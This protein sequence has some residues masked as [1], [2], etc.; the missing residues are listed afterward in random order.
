MIRKKNDDDD[1]RSG[2]KFE[3][4]EI[5]VA[6][7]LILLHKGRMLYEIEDRLRLKWGSKRRRSVLNDKD[8]SPSAI[9]VGSQTLKLVTCDVG[10]SSTEPAVKEPRIT[11]KYENSSPASPLSFPPSESEEKPNFLKRKR[12]GR[13]KEQL[14]KLINEFTEGKELLTKEHRTVTTYYDNL[15][16]LNSDLKAKIEEINAG[17]KIRTPK[18]GIGESSNA[19]MESCQI[20][21]CPSQRLDH[22]P[23]I[24]IDRRAQ[25]RGN[26]YQIPDL[27]VSVPEEECCWSEYHPPF[28]VS[29]ADVKKVQMA[30][31]ARK[32]RLNICRVKS[33]VSSANKLRYP[34]T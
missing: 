13:N 7:S 17:S 9:P 8:S 23:L 4:R 19:A 3:A 1:E 31:E 27:N 10:P 24:T 16:A 33:R 2:S 29:V 21:S 25:E 18:L 34:C 6:E 28:D 15:K 5:K 12:P 11:A 30:A 26:N 22:P 14:S 32:K 20:Q